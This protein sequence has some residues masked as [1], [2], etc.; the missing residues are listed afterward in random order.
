M[1]GEGKEWRDQVGA[2]PVA[3]LEEDWGLQGQRRWREAVGT[4]WEADSQ[5]Q[6]LLR[7]LEPRPS[8][9]GL[10]TMHFASAHRETS[11]AC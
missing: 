5:Q 1:Q 11:K 4:R 9:P 6:L 10:T 3:G 2:G 7:E 8:L